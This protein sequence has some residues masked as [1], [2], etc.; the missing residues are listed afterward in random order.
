M[1]SSPTP[2]T[3]QQLPELRDP[4]TAVDEV[5]SINPAFA[6]AAEHP[7][8]IAMIL[9]TIA[10]DFRMCNAYNPIVGQKTKTPIIGVLG[11]SDNL[12]SPPDM[13]GWHGFT[14]AGYTFHS[15]AGDHGLHENPSPALLDLLRPCLMGSTMTPSAESR[16]LGDNPRGVGFVT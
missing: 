14:T 7:E 2:G 16:Y 8:L 13:A 15:I 9:P 11:N 4:A 12:V 1:L 10:T 3:G 5:I 6:E